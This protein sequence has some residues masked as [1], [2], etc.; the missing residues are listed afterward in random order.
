MYSMVRNQIRA[1]VPGARRDL[2]PSYLDYRR[3]DTHAPQDEPHHTHRPDQQPGRNTALYLRS[4]RER[5][6]A[7]GRPA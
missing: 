1:A 5:P 4:A 3:S 6:G 7:G 2:K